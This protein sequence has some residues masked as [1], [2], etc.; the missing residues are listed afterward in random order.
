MSPWVLRD[1]TSDAEV[2]E[3]LRYANASLYDCGFE[4]QIRDD[5]INS[6]N[7]GALLDVTPFN[8]AG[9]MGC[10]DINF[11]RSQNEIDLVATP[12]RSAIQ[13]DVN[14][15]FVRRFTG[16]HAT[17]RIAEA[18]TRDCFGLTDETESGIIFSVERLRTSSTGVDIRN[19]TL[20]VLGHELGHALLNRNNWTPSK[21]E[22]FARSGASLPTHNIMTIPAAVDRAIF[23]DPDQCL[24]M[25]ADAT[26]FRGDP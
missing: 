14:V 6:F 8:E 17:T 7:A 10:G 2:R 21:R 15:Y 1:P 24:N 13:T 12:R 18:L 19:R 11:V 25:N 9:T 23:N 26:I 16:A 20:W 22:H 4:I 5:H 3:L